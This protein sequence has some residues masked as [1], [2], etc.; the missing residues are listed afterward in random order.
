MLVHTLQNEYP[1]SGLDA[2]YNGGQAAY[3]AAFGG[4]AGYSANAVGASGQDAYG[5][6]AM[7][8]QGYAA[9]QVHVILC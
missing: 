1:S 8:S 6:N 2:N 7:Y 9:S 3:G 4:Q 5:S